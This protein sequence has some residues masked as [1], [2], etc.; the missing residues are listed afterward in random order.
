MLPRGVIRVAHDHEASTSAVASAKPS[1]SNQPT[2]R[3]LKRPTTA[4]AIN[5]Q[6]LQ[7][8]IAQ[9]QEQS[10]ARA[11]LNKPTIVTY[12]SIVAKHSKR[13]EEEG[14]SKS[15][16]K[17]E[18]LQQE[19]SQ[20]RQVAV[21]SA[22]SAPVNAIAP[23]SYN[24]FL[25]HNSTQ[26]QPKAFKSKFL[27]KT[28]QER[29]DEYA[30]A[31]LRILGSAFPSDD[32]NED[33]TMSSSR[34]DHHQQQRY[35]YNSKDL[36]NHS[37]IAPKISIDNV[38]TQ[39]INNTGGSNNIPSTSSESMAGRHIRPANSIDNRTT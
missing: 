8:Q 2:V 22:S 28:Y 33:L 20:H 34:N 19:I 24:Q 25:E 38:A 36:S 15:L 27:P 16:T 12:S 1:S 14:P 18:G 13:K 39:L 6:N 35:R 9:Q 37:V 21:T 17:N 23:N 5:Q 4:A 26:Q 3:I 11:Q 29:A 31:R 7:P 10:A 30:K 32:S